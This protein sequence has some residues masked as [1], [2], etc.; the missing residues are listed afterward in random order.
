M[1]HYIH[2]QRTVNSEWWI[3][4]RAAQLLTN[5]YPLITKATGRSA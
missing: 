3:V 1:I 5:R 4:N 2:H